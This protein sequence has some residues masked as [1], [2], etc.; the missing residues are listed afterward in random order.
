MQVNNNLSFAAITITPEFYSKSSQKLSSAVVSVLPEIKK[1]SELCDILIGYPFKEIGCINVQRTKKIGKQEIKGTSF[2]LMNSNIVEIT[3]EIA[4][5]A[6]KIAL[7]KCKKN[8]HMSFIEKFG[9]K[10]ERA[11][12]DPEKYLA[13]LAK[14]EAHAE[15]IKNRLIEYNI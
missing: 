8:F 9:T 12:K 10:N 7:K 11:L 5:V 14:K 6:F 4:K 1:H 2:C 15:K 3:P 13:K